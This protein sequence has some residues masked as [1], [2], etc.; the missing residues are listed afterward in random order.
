[1]SYHPG[2]PKKTQITAVCWGLAQAYRAM[3]NTAQCPQEEKVSKSDNVTT[4]PAAA[5]TPAI[6][7]ATTPPL[8]ITL[9]TADLVS[10]FSPF[11]FSSEWIGSGVDGFLK[12]EDW[13]EVHI[14]K[15]L[16]FRQKKPI[17]IIYGLDNSAISTCSSLHRWSSVECI[18]LLKLSWHYWESWLRV[19][20]M[21]K[22]SSSAKL[23]A[24]NTEYTGE[25]REGFSFTSQSLASSTVIF[26]FP[27]NYIQT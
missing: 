3:F 27:L 19:Q 26:S 7:T 6:G 16:Y 4:G 10:I 18:L 13:P 25:Q 15:W 2:I 11:L 12:S 24:M 14:Q 22:P 21:S 17:K 5:P 1:M 20:E 23:S 9:H 8:E